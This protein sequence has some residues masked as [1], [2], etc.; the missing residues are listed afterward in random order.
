MLF[1]SHNQLKIELDREYKK[2][3]RKKENVDNYI[4]QWN[5]KNIFLREAKLARNMRPPESNQNEPSNIQ[6]TQTKRIKDLTFIPGV[7]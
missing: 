1:V 7:S 6:N 2:G 4:I 3:K 5:N